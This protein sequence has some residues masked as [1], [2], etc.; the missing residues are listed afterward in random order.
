ML[1]L[2][3]GIAWGLSAFLVYPANNLELISLFASCKKVRDDAGYWNQIEA[4]LRSHAE[5]GSVTVYARTALKRSIRNSTIS[6]PRHQSN[7]P[8]QL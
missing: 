4:Y 6:F 2:C 3:S 8:I 7:L 5:V 1:A